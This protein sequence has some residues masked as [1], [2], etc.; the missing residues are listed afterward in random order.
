MGFNSG[1]KVLINHQD[2]FSL[3]D[4]LHAIHTRF[5]PS[6][7]TYTKFIL[8]IIIGFNFVN[9]SFYSVLFFY[10]MTPSFLRLY[11]LKYQDRV[12]LMCQ[13]ECGLYFADLTHTNIIR[14]AFFSISSIAFRF[15]PKALNGTKTETFGQTHRLFE[16]ALYALYKG[17]IN[18]QAT[19]VIYIWS[20]YS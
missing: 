19:N 2:E 12:R 18:P 20:T 17:L 5:S 15:I 1:F 11:S 16:F 8:R 3:R 6:T 14:S 7:G 9:G 4:K 10:L 13:V